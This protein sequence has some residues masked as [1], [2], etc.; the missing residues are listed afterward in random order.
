MFYQAISHKTR[1]V[2]D[3]G[4]AVAAIEFA[5]DFDAIVWIA[6]NGRR[7]AAVADGNINGVGNPWNEVAVIDLDRK[8]QI[9]SITFGAL[10]PIERINELM[11]CENTEFV[12]CGPV[13]LPMD[14]EGE[15]TPA[16]FVCGC[17]G[18]S[19]VSSLSQQK[20]YDQDAGFGMCPRCARF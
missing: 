16:R 5:R 20:K 13:A 18:E 12:M 6:P 15:D 10:T 1:H 14:G 11:R 3:A 8:V 9:E 2:P 4:A 7:L 19:F 17:C